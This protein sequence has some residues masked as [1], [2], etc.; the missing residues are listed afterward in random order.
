MF[1]SSL[2]HLL[3][4][5]RRSNCRHRMI[6]FDINNEIDNQSGRGIT[7]TARQPVNTAV[8]KHTLIT[9]EMN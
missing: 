9:N 8:E 1:T 4:S 3:I 2:T 7:T 6:V 5:N